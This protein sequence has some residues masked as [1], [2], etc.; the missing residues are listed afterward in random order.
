MPEYSLQPATVN[1]IDA[2]L[3]VLSEAFSDDPVMQYMS[4]DPAFPRFAFKPLARPVVCENVSCLSACGQ[5]A[6]LVLPPGK[7]MKPE[8]S[9]E[10]VV[11]YFGFGLRSMIRSVALH[12]QMKKFHPVY[13]HYYLLAIGVKKS[14][15][16]SG[17]GGA[18]M[19]DLCAMADRDEQP[20]YLENSNE[21]NLGFYKNFGFI[22]IERIQV[23]KQGPYVWLMQ[24]EPQN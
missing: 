21:K 17:L 16:G 22:E 24:R 7:G 9:F 15:K 3:D 8:G 18:L 6:S 14:A 19:R 20:V 5:G 10:D 1:D 11:S 23:G 13:P 2:L 4:P 12:R